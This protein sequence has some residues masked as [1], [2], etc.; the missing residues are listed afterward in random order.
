MQISMSNNVYN[1][2][3]SIIKFTSKISDNYSNRVVNNIYATIEE[4]KNAPYTG[5]YVP[6]LKNHHYRERIC[7]NYRIIYFVSEIHKTIYI[8]YIISSRENSN[9]FFEVHKKELYR[10]LNQLLK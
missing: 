6:E 9:L 8:R 7:E 2:I 5:R 4:L 1:N 3:R 10:F